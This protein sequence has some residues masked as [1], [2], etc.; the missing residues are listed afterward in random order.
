MRSRPNW[1]VIAAIILLHGTLLAALVKLDM[2]EI[3]KPRETAP[4]IVELIPLPVAK[5]PP[6]PPAIPQEAPAKPEKTI[7][8]R[9]VTPAPLV[10]TVSPA[11]P[12]LANAPMPILPPPAPVTIAAPAEPAVMAG[13][14]APIAPPDASAANLGNDAPRYPIESRRRREEGT[15]RLRVVITPEGRVKEISIARSSGFERLDKAALETVRKWK[16]R[17][18]MQAGRAVEA[19]GFVPIPFQLRG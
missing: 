1:P 15:V 12:P 18:G 19:V 10:R 3:G 8:P 13:P 11:P 2:V 17:P 7:E 5:A 16:F 4:T 6:P 9:I 14:A